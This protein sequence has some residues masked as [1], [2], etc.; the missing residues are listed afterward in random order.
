[1]SKPKHTQDFLTAVDVVCDDCHVGND[2]VCLSC[3]VRITCNHGDIEP[4]GIN[5][6]A[7]P[8]MLAA[9]E[10]AEPLIARGINEGAYEHCAAPKIGKH[11]LS[12]VSAA[13]NKARGSE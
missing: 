1:M 13:I 9:L 10:I 5:P 7:V 6:E 12:Q 8:D 4:G 3:P 11:G 2:V